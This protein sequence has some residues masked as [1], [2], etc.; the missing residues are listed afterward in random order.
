MGAERR[1][2]GLGRDDDLPRVSA[3]LLRQRNDHAAFAG[4]RPESDAG[5][6]N[7]GCPDQII[8]RHPM[9]QGDG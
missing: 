3:G 4:S 2:T 8:Q 5:I 1:L 6:A 7:L 9:E